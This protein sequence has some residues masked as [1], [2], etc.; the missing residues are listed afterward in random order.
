M[1][2]RLGFRDTSM[3][4][5]PISPKPQARNTPQDQ[6]PCTRKLKFYLKWDLVRVFRVAKRRLG[7]VV[8]ACVCLYIYICIYVY[9]VSKLQTII[10]I[11]PFLR[12]PNTLSRG[13]DSQT[14]D[15]NHL[16]SINHARKPH[17]YG[18]LWS[19]PQLAHCWQP[20]GQFTC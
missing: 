1:V 6:R 9:S 5:K 19:C 13:K 7:T 12:S 18:G 16:D 20:P 3:P 8:G 10:A 4:M 11:L 17:Q 14:S 2:S 15:T